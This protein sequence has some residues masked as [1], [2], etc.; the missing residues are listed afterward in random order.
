MRT[1]IP[2]R[3]WASQSKTQHFSRFNAHLI[4]RLL[5]YFF[6]P[7]K[8]T[9][10]N[11]SRTLYERKYVPL[12]PSDQRPSVVNSSFTRVN[13]SDGVVPAR[14]SSFPFRFLRGLTRV[15]ESYANEPSEPCM[16]SQCSRCTSYVQ[17]HDT[18]EIELWPIRSRLKLRLSRSKMS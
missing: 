7:E 11:A 13:R 10:W 15:N 1:G 4:K 16:N 3:R 17:L 14:L 9:Q 6:R 5:E 8:T 12:Q 18:V 2:R